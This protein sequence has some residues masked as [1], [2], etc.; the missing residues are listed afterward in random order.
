MAIRDATAEGVPSGGCPIAAPEHEHEKLTVLTDQ[1]RK[2]FEVYGTSNCAANAMLIDTLRALAELY[3]E[4]I[5]KENY[6]PPMA[7]KLLSAADRRRLR[8]S[9]IWYRMAKDMRMRGARSSSSARGSGCASNATNGNP[10]LLKARGT[11][12]S[13]A[14]TNPTEMNT[15]EKNG[16]RE[17]SET[18]PR[19]P[20]EIRPAEAAVLT[21]MVGYQTEP[22]LAVR[23]LVG[24]PARSHFSPSMKA[25]VSANT[26]LPSTRWCT[27]WREKR[28]S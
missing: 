12:V 9:C 27:F 8:I 25:R 15:T 23:F 6:P 16:D 28:R 11:H 20:A 13:E 1:L 3:C 2:E 17:S 24:R 19:T 7:D 5:W 22:W 4:H 10:A 18:K 14:R 26:Q 21:D